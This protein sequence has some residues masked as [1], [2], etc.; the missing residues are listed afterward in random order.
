MSET[1]LK[2]LLANC[3]HLLVSV[4]DEWWSHKISCVRE[5]TGNRLRERELDE[6][7]SWFGGMGS[8]NDLIISGQN[9]HAVSPEEESAKNKQF[10]D[11][12]ERIYEVAISL[13]RSD[14]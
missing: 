6:I 2:N 10:R 4:K 13:K 12:K 7:L 14:S 3:E 5:A 9:G 1:D 11:Y 8:F